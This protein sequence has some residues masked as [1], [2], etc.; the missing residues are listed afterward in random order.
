MVLSTATACC[1]GRLDILDPRARRF[2]LYDKIKAGEFHIKQR[3]RAFRD[4]LDTLVEGKSDPFT[5]SPSPRTDQLPDRWTRLK[6]NADLRGRTVAEISAREAA[7][8]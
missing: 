1:L 8:S 4:I 3:M 6:A 7:S 2:R 5:A